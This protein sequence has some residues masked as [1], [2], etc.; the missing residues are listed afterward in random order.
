[1]TQHRMGAP[2][3]HRAGR[4]A[5]PAL[6]ITVI[7]AVMFQKGFVFFGILHLLAALPRRGSKLQ[8]QVA[9]LHFAGRARPPT[10]GR[11]AG[12]ATAP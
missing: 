11:G 6:A 3:K 5:I 12:V 2:S 1:M 4:L 10:T 8:E 9:R 7:S